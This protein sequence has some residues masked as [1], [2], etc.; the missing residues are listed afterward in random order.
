MWGW[1]CFNVAECFA[2]VITLPVAHPLFTVFDFNSKCMCALYVL[3]PPGR[4][5][6]LV[7]TH[8]RNIYQV[9]WGR[10]TSQRPLIFD[11]LLIGPFD[12]CRPSRAAACGL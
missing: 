7:D 2:Q 9:T 8:S 3:C 5:L 6:F 4:E 11:R 12:L 1:A 10:E